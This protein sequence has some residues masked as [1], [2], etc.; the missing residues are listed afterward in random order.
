[1]IKY[2]VLFGL[3]SNSIFASDSS[4]NV[5][6]IY[7]TLQNDPCT[8]ITLNVHGIGT[9]D[10]LTIYYDHQP[11]HTHVDSYAYQ[12]S[13]RGREMK[14]L[15]DHRYIYQVELTNLTPNT[16]Y[17]FTIGDKDH[18]FSAEC[19]FKTLANTPPYRFVEGGDWE[20]TKAASTLATLAASYNPEVI[21]LGGDYPSGVLGLQDYQK[22]DCW[23]DTYCST[24]RTQEGCLIPCIMA[25]GNHEVIGGF[26]S[27]PEHAPFYFDYFRQGN[28]GTSYFS[29]PLGSETK[30]FVLDSGH[31][32][33]HDGKQLDWLESELEASKSAKIKL[34]LYHVPIYPSIRF[35]KKNA[36]YKAIC[37]FLSFGKIEN[38]KKRLY[39]YA[40]LAGRKHWLP[41][42]DKYKMTVAFEHH[43]QTLKRT[44]LLRSGKPHPEGTL[45]L[46]DGNWGSEIQYPPI[47]GYFNS[48][49]KK[50]KGKSH[51]FWLVDIKP[52][53][54]SYSAISHENTIL[55]RSVQK[56][57]LP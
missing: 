54:I 33:R 42:F 2:L 23:L 6:H 12:C 36:A 28:T 44:K 27:K 7:L 49:F 3:I 48:Y 17:Y 38:F 14:K 15:P 16:I 57:D 43:D 31:T 18:A 21:L 50:L 45:Y 51:F 37:Y 13:V 29:L 35:V 32:Q 56:V 46:G 24:M 9:P 40:S 11:H 26:G 53:E 5:R 41:L 47:Q 1:M 10:E 52:G 20:N 4:L 39:S 34:A 55:D 25:I 30:L 22:W 8:T 19:A